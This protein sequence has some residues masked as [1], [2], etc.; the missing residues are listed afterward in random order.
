[1]NARNSWLGIIIVFFAGAVFAPAARTQVRVADLQAKFERESN[2]VRKAKLLQKL[3]EAQLQEVHREQLRE[4]YD[5]VAKIYESYRDDVKIALNA[6]KGT[7]PDAER[8]SD[9]YRQMQIELR[10]GLRDLEETILSTPQ[11]LRPRLEALRADLVRFDDDLIKLLFPRRGKS[12]RGNPELAS[13]TQEPHKPK[14]ANKFANDYDSNPPESSNKSDL[15]RRSE[16]SHAPGAENQPRELLDPPQDTRSKKDYLSDLEAD[17]IR[18]AETSNKRIKLLLSFAADR[19]KKFKYELEHPS[20]SGH[21]PEMLV[22]LMNAYAGCVDDAA[23][24]IDVGR[25]KQENIHEGIKEMVAKGKE[26]L[27][28][29]QSLS[30]HG[31]ERA[32]YKDTLDDAIEGTRDAIRDAEKAKKEIAPPP[33][34]RRN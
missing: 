24:Y 3:G 18:D 1:M 22:F 4:N 34:R 10:K 29:L 9:G 7:R 5:A 14:L 26:F 20:P 25:E 33:V 32:I 15:P 30:S 17:K 2:S 11:E 13:E 28:V 12:V 8:H 21:H 31:T 27:A 16:F 6:L 23:E 19:L